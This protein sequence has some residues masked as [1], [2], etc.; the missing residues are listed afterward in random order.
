M[1]TR[2]TQVTWLEPKAGKKWIG[3][4]LLIDG[5]RSLPPLDISQYLS[6][7]IHISGV[8]DFG[9]STAL[10]PKLEQEVYISRHQHIPAHHE[11]F[12][13]FQGTFRICFLKKNENPIITLQFRQFLAPIL[14]TLLALAVAGFEDEFQMEDTKQVRVQDLPVEARAEGYGERLEER[15]GHH[16]HHNAEYRPPKSHGFKFRRPSKGN[17]GAPPKQKPAPKPQYGPPK[18]SPKPQYGPPKHS[19]KP[20]Y[21]PPKHSPKPQY[22]APKPHQPPKANHRPPKPQYGAPKPQYGPPKHSPKPQYGPPKAQYSPAPAYETPAYP[23][24]SYSPLDPTYPAP[25]YPSPPAA[26]AYP[27]PAAAS[28]YPAPAY[29]TAAPAPAYPAAPPAYNSEVPESNYATNYEPNFPPASQVSWH[30]F[31]KVDDLKKKIPLDFRAQATTGHRQIIASR[32][33][34]PLTS[35]PIITQARSNIHLL[36]TPKL[37][38]ILRPKHPV[39][40]LLPTHKHLIRLLNQPTILPIRRT[41]L[42][43]TPK[44]RPTQR[45][46]TQRLLIHIPRPQVT[47]L[48][49]TQKRHSILP[50]T[51]TQRLLLPTPKLPIHHHQSQSILHQIFIGTRPSFQWSTK[52]PST[53]DFS[54][55]KISPNSTISLTR[56]WEVKRRQQKVLKLFLRH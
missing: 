30:E 17:Y 4:T 39:T 49:S 12:G 19:P 9:I 24:P 6:T 48:K 28:A 35:L 54:A 40:I 41:L 11:T 7:H 3:W 13:N 10:S 31:V 32:T 16:H 33:A 29:S 50:N 1:D 51:P 43:A 5:R 37:R 56:W 8:L 18:H 21:G 2:E 42:P 26:P 15:D 14:L 53:T 34:R 25:V 47:N 45:Q 23:A 52:H 46:P 44:L 20:Q 22:G 27:A 36:P 38:L 55:T